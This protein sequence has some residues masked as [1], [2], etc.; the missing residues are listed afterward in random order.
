MWRTRF[1]KASRRS[2]L[3]V[4][5]MQPLMDSTTSTPS[6]VCL[7]RI[8]LLSMSMA[9]Y[10]R[11]FLN[12]GLGSREG[13]VQLQVVHESQLWSCVCV[14]TFR[15]LSSTTDIYCAQA[16]LVLNYCHLESMI[17]AQDCVQQSGLAAPKEACQN[18]HTMKV[19]LWRMHTCEV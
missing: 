17:L 4:Q 19:G 5:Q 1:S 2:A 18:L 3:T 14:A 12:I 7:E 15:P 9:P 13:K 8:R 10:C 16:H 11:A 6:R